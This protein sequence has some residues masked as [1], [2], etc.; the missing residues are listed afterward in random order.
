MAAVVSP[1]VVAIDFILCLKRRGKNPWRW[2]FAKNHI[3]AHHYAGKY[4]YKEWP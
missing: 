4:K 1:T 2:C 3:L